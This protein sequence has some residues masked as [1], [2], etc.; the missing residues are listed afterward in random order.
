[1]ESR[2]S[3]YQAD[4]CNKEGETTGCDGHGMMELGVMEMEIIIPMV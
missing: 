3:R 4:A 1:M 2:G